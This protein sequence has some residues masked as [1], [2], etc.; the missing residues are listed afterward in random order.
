MILFSHENLLASFTK[1]NGEAKYVH[2]FLHARTED[3]QLLEMDYIKAE[4]LL[5]LIAGAD[6]MA[7]RSKF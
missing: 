2:R 6:T 1:H 7:L 5:I 3:D 4:I